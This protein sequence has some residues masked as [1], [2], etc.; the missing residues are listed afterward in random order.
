[1]FSHVSFSCSSYLYYLYKSTIWE[2]KGRISSEGHTPVEVVVEA[3]GVRAQPGVAPGGRLQ[4]E[5]DISLA[6]EPWPVEVST[7][8]LVSHVWKRHYLYYATRNLKTLS[9]PGHLKIL[10][11]TAKWKMLT[12]LVTWD[13]EHH[14]LGRESAGGRGWR[15]SRTQSPPTSCPPSQ[16]SRSLGTGW[17][18]DRQGDRRSCHRRMDSRQVWTWFAWWHRGLDWVGGRVILFGRRGCMKWSLQHR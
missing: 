4:H 10:W 7:N 8:I 14:P 1:M 16:S 2:W 3:H 6:R 12:A 15:Q 11:Y 17:T 13:Q 5:L 18:S 9:P